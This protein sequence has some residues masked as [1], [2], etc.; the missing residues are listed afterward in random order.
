LGYD[1]YSSPTV[2]EG[3]VYFGTSS[4]GDTPCVRGQIWALDA[5]TGA[6]KWTVDAID[7]TTCPTG[8]NCVGGGVWTSPAVD[9]VNHVV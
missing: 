7:Q 3:A 4:V 5:L 6:T 9:T 1:I 2:Y 8:N